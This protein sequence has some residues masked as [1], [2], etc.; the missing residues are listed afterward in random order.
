M[1]K[2]NKVI[3]FLKKFIRVVV[4][5]LYK[6][7]KYRHMYRDAKSS[8]EKMAMQGLCI[9]IKIV[10][11]LDCY[12]KKKSRGEGNGNLCSMRKKYRH[13]KKK[14]ECYFTDAKKSIKII[15]ADYNVRNN[16]TQYVQKLGMQRNATFFF[17]M[18]KI[19]NR[20]NAYT[21][22][23]SNFVSALRELMKITSELPRSSAEGSFLTP[24][25]RLFLFRRTQINTNIRNDKQG[26]IMTAVIKSFSEEKK[27]IFTKKK[28]KK[29]VPK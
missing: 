9:G 3:Q 28:R 10:K 15:N 20:H 2:C 13:I 24:L 23:G 27:I 8:G 6:K 1:N 16:H 19:E 25:T 26:R 14:S 22:K 21:K 12:F 4:L 7:K 17:T 29:S 5:F 11:K 18:F